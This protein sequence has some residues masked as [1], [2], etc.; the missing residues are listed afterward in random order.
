MAFKALLISVKQDSGIRKYT[1]SSQSFIEPWVGNAPIICPYVKFHNH[2]A[3]KMHLI[4]KYQSPIWK[5]MDSNKNYLC[6]HHIFSFILFFEL[7]VSQYSQW[8]SK[9]FLLRQEEL[10]LHQFIH[11]QS[12]ERKEKSYLH[13]STKKEAQ[14][15]Y[16]SYYNMHVFVGNAIG[17]EKTQVTK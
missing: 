17:P 10:K 13:H 1:L 2:N 16:G 14:C 4:A 3:C 9:T 6:C 5:H 7:Q 12:I 15:S 8:N 11:R